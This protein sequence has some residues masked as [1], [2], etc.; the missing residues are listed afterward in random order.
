MLY[1]TVGDAA[2]TSNAQDPKSLNG[3]ILRMT[4]T[5]AVP[6]DNPTPARSSTRWGTAI[7]RG[8]P[9]MRD[10]Q[11]WAS[12]FG[13]NTWDE[14]NRIEP[15]GNYGWPTVEGIANNA[16]LHRPGVPVV[17]VGGEPERPRLR[18]RHLLHGGAARRATL[19]DLPD[20]GRPFD[21]VA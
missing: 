18:A 12:E 19:G 11:L 7:R 6:A 14:L 2:Q 20:G 13:Q 15:G 17:D 10:G 4:L 3:K 16:G 8:W 21:A 5:G 9:G 1:A